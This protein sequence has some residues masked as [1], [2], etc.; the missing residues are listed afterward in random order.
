M[1]VQ[2]GNYAYELVRVFE[3]LTHTPAGWGF[4]IYQ[5]QPQVLLITKSDQ[6][7]P[8]REHCE[9]NARQIVQDLSLL[10]QLPEAAL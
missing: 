9:R 6:P 8:N 1:R 10:D 5:T 7:W 3:K 2:V 4:R